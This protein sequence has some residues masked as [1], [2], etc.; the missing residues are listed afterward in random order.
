MLGLQRDL[1][2]TEAIREAVLGPECQQ[3]AGSE[4]AKGGGCP[5]GLRK[6]WAAHGGLD[7]RAATGRGCPQ[8]LVGCRGALTAHSSFPSL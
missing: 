8:A 4:P 5:Q 3:P 7:A 2:E 6:A 1:W